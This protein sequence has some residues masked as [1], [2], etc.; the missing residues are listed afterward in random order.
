MFVQKRNGNSEPVSFDKITERIQ[1]MCSGPILPE[2]ENKFYELSTIDPRMI[3]FETIKGMTDCMKTEE[4]DNLTISVCGGLFLRHPDYQELATRLMISNLHKKTDSDLLIVYEELYENTDILAPSFMDIIR[5]HYNE[6]QDMID[7]ERDFL[8]DFFGMKTLER[9][10][11]LKMRTIIME[12]PQHMF[13]RVAIG[14]H[15]HDMELVKQT[16]DYMS[17]LYFTHATPTL[18][19]S[20]SNKPQLSSCFLLGID[21]DLEEIFRTITGSGMISKW[22]GGLGIHISNIRGKNSII[23]GTNGVSNGII[24]LCRVFNEVAL[25]INQGGKRPG[26]IAIYLEPWHCDIQDF[27]NLRRREGDEMMKARDLFMALWIPDLFMK[28][29]ETNGIWSL[30]CPYNCPGLQD[31]Y[32]EEFENLYFKYESEGKYKEQINAKDLWIQIIS[33]QIETGMPYIAYKDNVNRKTNHQNIGVIKSSNL[34]CEI[35]EYSDKDEYAVCNLASICLPRFIK[36]GEYDFEELHRVSKIVS[37]NL[38]KIIDINFYPVEQARCS[39]MKHRPIGIGVQGLVDVYQQLGLPYQSAEAFEL[40]RK[41]F[42]TIYH[43]ALEQSNETAMEIGPYETF[44]GSPFSQGILQFHMWEQEQNESYEK[45]YDWDSLIENIKQYGTRNSLVTAVMPTAST[46]QIMGNNE[47]TEPYTT[48][49]YLRTT[50]AGEFVVMNK[51]L[52]KKL[53]ELNLWTDDIRN[54]FL[55]DNGSIQN[56]DDI[57]D[58]IKEIYKTAFEIPQKFI[59]QQNLDR[60]RFI[61]QSQSQNLFY[62]NPNFNKLSNAL[63]YSHKHGGKTGVYYLR[64]QSAVDAKKFGLDIENEMK[65]KEKRGGVG[66]TQPRHHIEFKDCETCSA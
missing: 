49:M 61:D 27:L 30:M 5:E 2:S 25:Y 33:T 34:C 9:S 7:F 14:I 23:N 16:Y 56:I 50:N 6:L 46:S 11:L 65:I 63:F 21:D 18:F 38:N 52:I 43:G 12:R 60:G 51:N 24:P 19:N 45:M 22:A 20:G 36:N 17:Q 28:R 59:I 66:R 47:C 1:N 32:G 31:V 8:I 53:I 37:K 40:N 54:E 10:Y 4:I 41:I 35:M 39:N 3:A 26:S 62:A 58:D 15:G 55:Y 44:E 42:E 57:P 13:L 48:N 29:V 64:S